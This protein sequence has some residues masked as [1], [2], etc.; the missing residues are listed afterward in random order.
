VISQFHLW[1]HL[2]NSKETYRLIRT[3][4]NE[5]YRKMVKKM[6]EVTR[7]LDK[8]S[9]RGLSP[10]ERRQMYKSLKIYLEDI[11]FTKILEKL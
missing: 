1:K 3:G 8:Y 5:P 11:D 4:K 6:K 9:R 7:G 10:E 2:A